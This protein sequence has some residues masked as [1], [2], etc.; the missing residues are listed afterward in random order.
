MDADEVENVEELMVGVVRVE[1]GQKRGN[2]CC[3]RLF[4]ERTGEIV[5]FLSVRECLGKIVYDKVQSEFCPTRPLG[6]FLL[7]CRP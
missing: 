2:V 7:E 4:G 5:G 3:G 6:E 1:S